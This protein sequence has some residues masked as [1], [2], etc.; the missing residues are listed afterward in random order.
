MP[1]VVVKKGNQWCVHRE[2]NN[3][4]SGR[5]LGCHDSKEGARKQQSALYAE[6]ARRNGASVEGATFTIM[7][8][9]GTNTTVTVPT[10]YWFLPSASGVTTTWNYVTNPLGSFQVTPGGTDTA[11]RGPAFE[12]VLAVIGSPTSDGRYLI[13]DEISN[14]DLP[15]PVMVQTATEQGHMGAES[16]GRI[17][18]IDYIPIADFAQ[19]NEF[20][21]MDVRDEAVIVWA[22]G[23]FDTS[24]FAQD[25]ERMME[26]GAGVSIDMPPDRIAAFDPETLKEVPE[27][28]IDFQALMEGSYLIGIGGKIAALTIVSIPAFEQASIVLVPGHALVASAYGFRM[29]PKDVLTA[30]AAGA[31]PLEPPKD[32]FYTEEPDT[33]TPLTVTSDGHVYGHL[34]LWNQCHPAFASCERA[35]R[36]RSG[37]SYFHVGEIETAEGDLIPVGRI[38]VGQGGNAKGGHASVVLGRPGAM[39]HYD[40]TGCVAAFVRAE[41]GKNGI[42]LSGVV[43][44]DAPAEKVRDLRA[45]PPSG[46][47]REDELVA[48]LS[49]PVP[50]FPIPRIEALIASAENGE[51]EVK[52]LIASGY[53]EEYKLEDEYIPM[54]VPTYRRRMQE[55][56]ERRAVASLELAYSEEDRK[57]MAKSGQ[58]MPD[59]SFPIANCADAENAIHAQGRAKD[60][61]AA[62]AHIKKRVRSLRCNG[63]IFDDYK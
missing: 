33:P 38:T 35:P 17:E 24:K 56:V 60:Q 55:L 45:N 63:K 62:V 12:G 25:A 49:V 10:T 26:N 57:R 8:M 54:D 46:D 18:S 42:W 58:A 36:S 37:Y 14:R 1:Y 5:S 40:K 28:E 2:V 31:A 34:A 30:A 21:L 50:G 32:W 3:R 13:P 6:E 59:G 20:N 43:R 53:S 22:T 16:C 23:T 39:E 51:E 11:E 41:D 29:K 48:V 27:E 52:T 7:N 19:R 61:A 4:A 9:D 47:W 44:S 15:I